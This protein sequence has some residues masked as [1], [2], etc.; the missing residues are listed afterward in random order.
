MG[1]C[2]SADIEEWAFGKGHCPP[3]IKM[4]NITQKTNIIPKIN[5]LNYS[6]PLPKTPEEKI[7]NEKIDYILYGLE[8]DLFPANYRCN[9]KRWSWGVGTD[10]PSDT[11]LSAEVFAFDRILK[12]NMAFVINYSKSLKCNYGDS[13]PP[14]LIMNYVN[15]KFILTIECYAR[16]GNL[17]MSCRLIFPKDVAIMYIRTIIEEKLNLYDLYNIVATYENK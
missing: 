11:K 17:I 3:K 8:H 14:Q 12:Q 13:D 9:G 5:H 6:R 2:Y 15:N 4:T 1:N 16:N 10:I 7:I